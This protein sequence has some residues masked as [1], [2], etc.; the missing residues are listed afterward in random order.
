MGT[1]SQLLPTHTPAPRSRGM[2]QVL[3]IVLIVCGC[4]VLIC[5]GGEIFMTFWVKNQ[6]A[7]MIVHLTSIVMNLPRTALQGVSECPQHR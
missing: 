1:T 2:S 4:L 6:A 5:C 7:N 3:L